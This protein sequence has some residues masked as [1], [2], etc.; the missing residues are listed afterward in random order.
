MTASGGVWRNWGR[1]ESV[2]P[3]RVERPTSV[4]AVQRAVLAA[5]RGGLSIKAV[6]AG[7]S[8]TGIAVAPGVQ[9][10]LSDLSVGAHG[11][12]LDVD[13]DRS[14]VRLLAGTHLH[15]IPALLAPHGL[16]MANLG[17]I[18]GQTIA[19]AISTGTHGTGGNWGG[20]ATQVVALTLVTGDGSLLTVSETENADLLPAARLGLGALG[21]L[22]D[23][24]LQCV[25]AFLLHAMEAVEPLDA[26]MDSYL[27]RSARHDHFE[28]YWFPHTASALTKTNTRMPADTPR[29]PLGRLSRFL[30]DEVMAN[31]AYRALCA[32]GSVVPPLIPRFS[33]LAERFSARREYTDFSNRVFVARRAV[34]FREMEY[35]LPRAA[36]PDALREVRALIERKGWSISFP[37]EV[38]SAAADDVWL[39]TAYGRASGYIAVHRYYREDPA[40]YFRAVEA[41]MREHDGR[42][43]WGKLHFQDAA[44]LEAMYPHFGDFLAVRNRLDPERRFSNAYLERVLGP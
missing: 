14:R 21:I 34:R 38:R 18:D 15:R 16:A 17:D 25:P 13:R 8:F 11:A 23:V 28:F 5:G 27:E 39:S 22:V 30:D 37:I 9:I 20:L 43:H 24:T 4:G 33:R 6:G 44:S 3:L 41:I 42:P 1:T 12:L 7:H 31:A 2:R 36:I 32:V 26:A 35:A 40:E 19:G 10:D 29:A